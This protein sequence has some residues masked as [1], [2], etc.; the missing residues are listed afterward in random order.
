MAWYSTLSP[1]SEPSVSTSY[2]RS[3]NG[4]RLHS[5][6]HVYKSLP[7]RAT[8]IVGFSFRA[9]TFVAGKRMCFFR[10]EETTQMYLEV[11]ASGL[12]YIKRGDGTTLGVSTNALSPAQFYYLEFKVTIS[13]TSGSYELR[14]KRS[15]DSVGVESTGSLLDTQVSTNARV[16]IFG[17][18]G[19]NPSDSADNAFDFDDIYILDTNGTRNN[20]FLGP[21]G[22]D[23]LF[24]NAVGTY[25]QWSPVGDSPNWDATYDGTTPDGDTSYVTRSA[26]SVGTDTYNYQNMRNLP[27]D[28]FGLG[29]H[30]YARKEYGNSAGIKSVIRGGTLDSIGGTVRV[31][32]DPLYLQT[33]YKYHVDIYE[34]NPSGYSGTPEWMVG[35]INSSE[36]GMVVHKP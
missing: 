29:I 1:T 10:D 15:L 13:N 8:L 36:Y 12:I 23:I 28:I 7:D 2:G 19:G 11:G 26:V 31:I 17:L 4:I 18:G 33:D 21:S 3:G 5:G 25:S 35:A 32:N 14:V 30:T 9:M 16:N 20:D 6:A 24:P 22:V 27:G 34:T